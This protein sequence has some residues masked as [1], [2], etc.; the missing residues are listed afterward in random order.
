MPEG[1]LDCKVIINVGQEGPDSRAAGGTTIRGASV[2]ATTAAVATTAAAARNVGLCPPMVYLL[3]GGG[4]FDR[5]GSGV[6]L[7]ANSV[8]SAR[9]MDIA[10]IRIS[11]IAFPFTDFF[12]ALGGDFGVEGNCVCSK[13]KE[14]DGDG[15]LGKHVLFK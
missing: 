4:G 1:Y 9:T 7:M 12:P 8:I 6:N 11:H 10:A 5:L 15:S 13:G 2:T 3:G 14:G